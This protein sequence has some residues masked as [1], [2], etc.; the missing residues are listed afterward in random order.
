MKNI[1]LNESEVELKIGKEFAK[2]GV[3]FAGW[4]IFDTEIKPCGTE[5][6]TIIINKDLRIEMI[7]QMYTSCM[8]LFYTR[9]KNTRERNVFSSLKEAILNAR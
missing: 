6:E 5:A 7:V 9:N 3:S 8:S 4:E 2:A 1:Y